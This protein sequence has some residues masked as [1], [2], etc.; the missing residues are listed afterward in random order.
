MGANGEA[1]GQANGH[2]SS[3]ISSS[4]TD[5]IFLLAFQGMLVLFFGLFA[6]YGDEASTL[7]SCQEI[8]T[9][10]S[11]IA[12]THCSWIADAEVCISRASDIGSRY[13]LFQDVHV[14]IFVGFGFLMTFL[15]K[16]GFSSVGLNFLLAALALQWSIFTSAFWHGV[17][18]GE[19]HTITL[20]IQTLIT[21]D[22]GAGAVLITFGALLGKTTPLQL[23]LVVFFEL[24]FFALN[25]TIGV[26]EC[27]AV[28][29]GGSMFVHTFGAYFGLA[30]SLMLSPKRAKDHKDNGSTKHSDMFAMIGTLFLWMFWPS[31]N[32]ALANGASQHRVVVNT[33]LSLAACCVTSFALSKLMRPDR[34][35]D[36]VDIQNATLAG[37]VAVGSSADLVIQPWGAALIG[38]IAAL[39][40]VAGYVYLQPF[41]E[42]KIG[43]HDT[44]GV[45]NLHGLPGVLG[46]IGGAVSAAMASDVVYGSHIKFIFEG[47]GPPYNRSAGV[48]AGY[49]AAALAITLGVSIF[50]GLFTG[51]LI[52]KV[53]IEKQQKL[54]D[55]VE[56]WEVPHEDTEGHPVKAR[57][58][59]LAGV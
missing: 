22:F 51:F 9:L 1:N 11:C 28:D 42:E 36:M 10:D 58:V 13:G 32:G 39:L 19:F 24:I 30:A 26:V 50:G 5:V 45:H 18:S 57:A 4:R 40:S 25:E 29:M 35:F 14:M 15:K 53:P 27:L 2:G 3:S 37:G 48:Q 31:F 47:R 44:C 6:E 54:F 59:E 41:L 46:G 43:L 23:G 12:E 56:Y 17:I 38:M 52:S 55:D 16:Y 33:V 7:A 21:G 8:E 34:K 49:Q 20:N